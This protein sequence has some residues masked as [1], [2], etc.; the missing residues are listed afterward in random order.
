MEERPGTP[1]IDE[2]NQDLQA[3]SLPDTSVPP[4]NFP[5]GEEPPF[6]GTAPVQSGGP[7]PSAPGFQ[8][9]TLG[10]RSQHR[11]PA[12]HSYRN[13]QYGPVRYV[14]QLYLFN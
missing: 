6:T 5:P 1:T 7:P 3:P 14:R 10:A 2:H 8:I 13:D 12:P 9:E 11:M 4:P